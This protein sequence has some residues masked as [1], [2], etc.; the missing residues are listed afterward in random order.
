MDYSGKILDSGIE[1]LKRTAKKDTR[2]NFIYKQKCHCGKVFD[3]T[4]RK[5][6]KSCGCLNN[7][8][9]FNAM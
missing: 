7:Y 5:S 2:G 8:I 6:R 4:F 1:I 9:P 3:N